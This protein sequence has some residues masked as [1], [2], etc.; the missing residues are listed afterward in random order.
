[1][2]ELIKKPLRGKRR[3]EVLTPEVIPDVNTEAVLRF[4]DWR[5]NTYKKPILDKLNGYYLFSPTPWGVESYT[6]SNGIAYPAGIRAVGK[7]AIA[8]LLQDRDTAQQKK[9]RQMIHKAESAET[10]TAFFWTIAVIRQAALA[11]MLKLAANGGEGT[12]LDPDVPVY[13]ADALMQFGLCLESPFENNRRR[14]KEEGLKTRLDSF[15]PQLGQDFVDF[16]AYATAHPEA[17]YSF[18]GMV[19]M[20]AALDEQKYQIATWA[21]RHTAVIESYPQIEIS[22]EILYQTLPLAEMLAVEDELSR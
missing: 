10:A 12:E 19:L 7:E 21:P 9:T 3:R 17:L 5:A 8:Q 15:G 20:E 14:G 22:R 1:M 2:G 6:K 18:D 13:A 11:E 16:G 4:M